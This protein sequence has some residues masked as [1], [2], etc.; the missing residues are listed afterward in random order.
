LSQLDD[1]PSGPLDVDVHVERRWIQLGVMRCLTLQRFDLAKQGN[2]FVPACTTREPL[3]QLP[4]PRP[5]ALHVVHDCGARF[6][7]PGHWRSASE[8]RSERLEGLDEI[9][10]KRCDTLLI[11][12]QL[13]RVRRRD[14]EEHER[15][16]EQ[17]K[18]RKRLHRRL[19]D[20]DLIARL[21]ATG[22]ASVAA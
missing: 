4:G 5:E 12:F 10:S 8:I 3:R 7:L 11:P 13:C 16:H 17:E 15:C 18:R 6:L 2:R 22:T 1:G 9:L 20:A 14:C 21:R 19:P